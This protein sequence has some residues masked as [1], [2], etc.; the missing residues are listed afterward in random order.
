M[1]IRAIMDNQL[2][3]SRHEVLYLLRSALMCTRVYYSNSEMRYSLNRGADYHKVST[4]VSY[5]SRCFGRFYKF[6][7]VLA[8]SPDEWM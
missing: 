7:L 1:K 6:H 3:L 8:D 5:T 2:M 4:R